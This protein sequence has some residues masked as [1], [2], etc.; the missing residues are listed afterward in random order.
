MP[1]VGERL[2]HFLFKY[3]RLVFEQGDFTWAVPRTLVLVVVLA[4]A[5]IVGALLTYRR[6]ATLERTSDHGR[7]P[8][9]IIARL[10]FELMRLRQFLPIFLDLR[11][12]RTLTRLGN[13]HARPCG[14]RTRQIDKI[15]ATTRAAASADGTRYAEQ[16]SHHGWR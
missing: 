1:V 9:R 13:Q 7:D 10:D 4:A 16:R 2:F 5:T 11:H 12:E 14:R 3:P 8:R 6:V 15:P